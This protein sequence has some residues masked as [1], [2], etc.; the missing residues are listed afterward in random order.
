M[1]RSERCKLISG[2]SLLVFV[3]LLLTVVF[4]SCP[5]KKILNFYFFS[6]FT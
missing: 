4:N 6:G 5:L 2:G 3:L 1:A